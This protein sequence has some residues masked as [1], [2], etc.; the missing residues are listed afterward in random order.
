VSARIWDL[1]LVFAAVAI[2]W[3]VT[4]RLRS[5]L[6]ASSAVPAAQRDLDLFW[7]GAL[8]YVGSYAIERNFDYRLVFL[9]LTVPQLLHWAR[10]GHRLAF[11]TI[12]AL[13]V[14]TWLDVWGSMPVV[15]SV[16]DSWNRL[17]AAGPDGRTLPIAVIGQFVL[18]GTLT[19]WLVATVPTGLVTRVRAPRTASRL[20]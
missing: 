6:A 18:F 16:L 14:T 7:A 9:L 3:L 15:G 17:T 8:V 10:A 4:R 11:V 12:G 13:L 1:A 5:S 19:A 20:G 2:A